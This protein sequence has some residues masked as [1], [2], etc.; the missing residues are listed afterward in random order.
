MFKLLRLFSI[1]SLL[2]IIAATVGLSLLQRQLAIADVTRLGEAGNVDITRVFANAYTEP[3]RE[4][5][6]LAPTLTADQLKIHP[7][8]TRLHDSIRGAVSGTDIVKIKAYTLDGRTVYSSQ[9]R[10]IGEDKSANRGFLAAR[11]GQ[12]VTAVTQHDQFSAFDQELVDRGVLSTYLPLR[13][14]GAAGPVDGV[15]EVYQDITPFLQHLDATQRKVIAGVAAILVL[16]FGLLFL[17]VRHADII[18]RRQYQ[19]GQAAAD[20]LRKTGGEL[21]QH[22]A[23]M[24][25]VDAWRERYLALSKLSADWFWDQDA[26]LR[27]ID[28]DSASDQYG[29]ISRNLHLGKARWELPYTEPVGTTWEAHQA[30]LAAH[31]PFRNLLLRRTPPTGPRYVNVS[32]EPTFA[33]DGSFTGYRGVASDVTERVQAELALAV[34]RDALAE[35]TAQHQRATFLQA[36]LDA[37]PVGVSLVDKN[38][39]LAVANQACAGLLDVPPEL[40]RQGSALESLYDYKAERGEFGPGDPQAIVAARMALARERVPRRFEEARRDGGAI[41][42]RG[43]PLPDGSLVTIYTDITERKRAEHELRAARDAAEAGSQAKSS[44]LAVMSHEIRTPMNAVIGL[45]ELLRLSP[46]DAEQRD[47]VDT[48]RESSKSLLRLIDDVL[49]FS[50]IESG[51]L[52]LHEEV[53]SLAQM[54]DSA[55]QNFAGVASQKGVLLAQRVDPRIAPA[56]MVDRLR[57]RQIVNNLLS[58]AIKFTARGQVELTAVLAGRDEQNDRV[59]IAVRDTGIGIGAPALE[60]L[61]EP[62]SQADAS[63]ERRYGGT[64]LGLAICK[65][66]AAL[67]GTTIEVQSV[68]GVGTSFSLTLSLRRADATALQDAKPLPI[69]AIAK[70][71]QGKSAPTVASARAEGRLILAVDDHPINRRMMARQLN[72][73]G[74]AVQ[75][76][77]DGREALELWRGGGFGLMITDCQMPIMDGYQ[78]ASAMRQIEIGAAARLPIVACT[79]NVSREALDQCLAVGMDDAITKPCELATLKRLLDRWLPAAATIEVELEPAPLE[80]DFAALEDLTQGDAALQRDLLD[81]FRKANADDL[82]AAARAVH[83]VAIDDV[84]RA[85]HRIKGAARTIGAA[86]LA[87]AAARLEEAAQAGDWQRVSSAWAPLQH[88]GLRLDERIETESR[89]ST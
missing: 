68:A 89:T 21:E 41:E 82:K 85:A 46:L 74:Y 45:L 80:T 28:L 4:F 76:A 11:A 57:L 35:R 27:F 67:M 49:D 88:E 9:A 15:F 48:V 86:R 81:D 19:Q 42:V 23:D 78:L 54:F 69:E 59:R 52:E 32:G 29:G 79:A 20:A 40:L 2:S 10:Q 38:L 87:N 33:V 3:L 58:N 70:A 71:V 17:I 24:R 64:G 73:L 65:R 34:A 62:F 25:Q 14:G 6:A 22:T 26:E 44:F 56:V 5:M 84:R 12:I 31:R 7:Q 61:F 37:L 43:V 50:K 30:E 51:K 55:Q 1:A 13:A 83:S 63:V 8:T 77:A 53:A 18:F 39:K 72:A 66:L 47:T 60:R 75:T 36:L 16:L